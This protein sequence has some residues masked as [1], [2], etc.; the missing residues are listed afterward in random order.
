M[1]RA[2]AASYLSRGA[3]GVCTWSLEWPLGVAARAI[4]TEFG[5][6]QTMAVKDKHYLLPR[7]TGTTRRLGL[8]MALPLSL[9][10]AEH[11]GVRHTLQFWIADRFEGPRSSVARIQKVALHLKIGDLLSADE[12]AFV[13][14]AHAHTHTHTHTHRERERERKGGRALISPSCCPAYFL[15]C[16]VPAKAVVL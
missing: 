14:H 16:Q 4:L 12:L 9:S 7:T 13:R 3:D 6:A 8:S 11:T 10:P 2:C 15:T 1:L 5:D